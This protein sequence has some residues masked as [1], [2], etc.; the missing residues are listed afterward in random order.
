VIRLLADGGLA[1]ESAALGDAAAARLRAAAHPAVLEVRQRGLWLGIELIDEA[2]PARQASERLM[3]RG[4]LAKDTHVTT[5]RLA[6]PLTV[7]ADE[8]GWAL[9]RLDDVLAGLR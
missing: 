5:L 1:A 6:P 3:G 8:L 9:E 4:V 2:P 7:T